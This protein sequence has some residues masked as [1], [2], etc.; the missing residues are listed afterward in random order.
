MGID[1]TFY[2]PATP[3]Q[4]TQY[5]ALVPPD[6]HFAPGVGEITIPT[7]ANLPRYGGRAGK[8]EPRF[9]RRGAFPDMVLHPLS[10]LPGTGPFIFEFQRS[11]LEQSRFL[12]RWTVSRSPSSRACLRRGNQKSRR[13]GPA[14]PGHPAHSWR[15]G[16]YLQP[17][18]GHAAA[19]HAASPDG[20]T[21]HRPLLVMRLLTPLG[22]RHASAVETV[23]AVQPH[24]HRSTHMRREAASLI[25]AAA[26]QRSAL[27]PRQ[28]S[29][30]G[31]RPAHRPGHCGGVGRN[32]IDH[33]A[34]TPY[35]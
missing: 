27:C 35:A 31:Q 34:A 23:R 7:Y 18:D 19:P 6:F 5:A 30:G 10:S 26:R 16:A 14:I 4:L 11:G 33:I 22:L 13:A 21:V 9:S 8:P 17:L 20:R 32:L 2:R 15:R 24:R 29:F 3:S 28:Q 25:H 12:T 1:H